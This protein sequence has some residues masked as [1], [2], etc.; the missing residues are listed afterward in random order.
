MFKIHKPS[1]L[2]IRLELTLGWTKTN[3]S[4]LVFVTI[5]FSPIVFLF[6]MGPTYGMPDGVRASVD[7][8]GMEINSLRVANLGLEALGT[9]E[10][11]AQMDENDA[12]IA[13]LFVELDRVWP[14]GTLRHAAHAVDV[15]GFQPDCGVFAG[16]VSSKDAPEINDTRGVVAG[17]VEMGL[18]SNTYGDTSGGPVCM[19]GVVV[20]RPTANG[21]ME[22]GVL[23]NQHCGDVSKLNLGSTIVDVEKITG[24]WLCDCAFVSIGNLTVNSSAVWTSWGPVH[25][26]GYRDFELGEWVELHGKNGYSLG[27]VLAVADAWFTKAYV[28]DVYASHGDSG[29]PLISL[30]NGMFGG[31]N[32]AGRDGMIDPGIAFGFAWSTVQKKLD[33]CG[34]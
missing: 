30:N 8:M 33:V 10:S 15:S 14:A 17:G 3:V 5:L 22:T 19:S 4:I 9:P 20:E 27:R 13:E 31:M 7:C 16:T 25:V 12:R 21:A 18:F 32:S 23:T 28:V 26:S 1:K 24:R 2:N 6:A 11:V 34:V 29:G